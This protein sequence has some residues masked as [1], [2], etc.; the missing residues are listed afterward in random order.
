MSAPARRRS[1]LTAS[2]FLTAY[3]VVNLGAFVAYAWWSAFLAAASLAPD[4][5]GSLR[6]WEK[7]VGASALAVLGTKFVRRENLDSWL[8]DAF[9][10]GK[11][12]VLVLA[13]F[14]D[15]TRASVAWTAVAFAI[16]YVYL[17]HPRHRGATRAI[18]MTPARFDAEVTKKEWT[19]EDA[20]VRWVVLFRADWSQRSLHLEPTFA[21]LS[22]D[23]EKAADDETRDD[24]RFAV[25]DVGRF[26]SVADRL[27]IRLDL[28]G[29]QSQVPSVVLFERGEERARLPRAYLE[30]TRVKG[31]RLRRVDLEA[32]LGLKKP[33]AR[34][35]EGTKKRRDAEKRAKKKD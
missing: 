1:A 4:A 23:A 10:Y 34:D 19:R 12:A 2:R 16:F 6:T 33:T 8:A 9:A 31:S 29:A 3:H 35:G 17:P 32:G 11:S 20:R 5:L 30:G 22:L 27:G 24:V 18:E 25:V 7:Q 14:A 26:P 15:E 21:D 13:Y 28:V